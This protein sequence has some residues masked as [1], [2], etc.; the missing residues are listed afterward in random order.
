MFHSSETPFFNLSYWADDQYDALID[1]AGGQT[2]VDRDA[3][4]AT[5]E[6]AMVRLV[7]QSPGIFFYDTVFP[8][9]IPNAIAGYAV[10]PQLS[11]RAVLLPPAPGRLTSD[12]GPRGRHRPPARPAPLTA[13]P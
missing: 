11:V 6:E 13:H 10:Q 9:A 1:E 12:P 8:A 2:G 4:Q 7:D 5:Y 3:A